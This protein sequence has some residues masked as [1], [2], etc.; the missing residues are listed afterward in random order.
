MI[1]VNCSAPAHGACADSVFITVPAPCITNELRVCAA[2]SRRRSPVGRTRWCWVV[3][4]MAR[5][6]GTLARVSGIAGQPGTYI[7]WNF[8]A[9]RLAP[10]L[11]A[12]A[13]D[14]SGNRL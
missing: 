12:G 9:A 2:R 10:E 4:W 1:L 5:N 3:G 8:H 13:E 14:L 11:I 7:R 6:R